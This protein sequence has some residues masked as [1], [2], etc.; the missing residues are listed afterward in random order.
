MSGVFARRPVIIVAATVVLALMATGTALAL[1]TSPSTHVASLASA[2]RSQAALEITAGT[3]V[4]D[5]SIARLP[6]TLLRVST[7]DAAPVKPVR[8]DAGRRP[9][10]AGAVR[11]GADRA[12]ADRQRFVQARHGLRGQRGAELGRG[13]EPGLRGRHPA[14]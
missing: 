2:G 13:V 9:G 8:L 11:L 7:P 12:V 14:D 10:Q 1:T 6:G 3:P 5:V 4:L